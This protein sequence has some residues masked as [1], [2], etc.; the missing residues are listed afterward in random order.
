VREAAEGDL[1][2][3]RFSATKYTLVLAHDNIAK[4]SADLVDALIK[5]EKGSIGARIIDAERCLQAALKD[6]AD[7]FNSLGEK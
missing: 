6:L 2:A 3:E 5:E 1:V 7:A 4:A